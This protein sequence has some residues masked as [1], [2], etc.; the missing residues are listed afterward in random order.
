MA[1]LLAVV[2]AAGEGKRMKS[3]HSKLTHKILGKSMIEWVHAT[4]QEAGVQDC[5]LIVGHKAEEV[6]AL[7]Q[8]KAKYAVQEQQLGTGHAVM[9]AESFIKDRDG[10]VIIMCGDMPLVSRETIWQ[11]IEKHIAERNSATIL[12]ADFDNPTGYGRIVKD[13]N[14]NVI[15]ITEEKDA[16]AEE[17]A[18]KEVNSGLYCFK[19][20][21]LVEALKGITNKNQQKEYY[22]TD[23]IEVLISKSKK[24]NTYK[25]KNNYEIMGINDRVQL[26]QAT[27][28]MRKVILEKHMREGVTIIDPNTVYISKDV[29]IGKDTI[30]YPGCIIEGASAIGEDCILGPN[31]RIVDS[32]I[33]NGAQIQNSVIVEST[34]HQDAVIGPFAYLRPGSMIGKS[35]KV[36]DFVEIKN[37]II[38]NNS[39]VPHLSYVGDADV[40]SNVNIGCGTVLVNFDGKT[41]HRSKIGDNVF[42]GCNSNLVSPVNIENNSYIAAGST[43]TDDVP[44]DA[45]A[46]ARE[47]QV[48]KKDWVKKFKEEK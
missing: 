44:E 40:G 18:I 38:G 37:S 9:Q 24:V 23:T 34:I 16:T 6:K 5:V 17:K 45:L 22:L 41:K 3:K 11:S 20:K 2:L 12:T 19:A 48:N 10:H 27:E 31:V 42:V 33:L 26:S 4:L 43:I 46:I 14:G 39:K 47:R 7:I 28:I 29:A 25:I 32:T 36:G 21:D 30:I 1:E 35:V 8:D 13:K 15:K